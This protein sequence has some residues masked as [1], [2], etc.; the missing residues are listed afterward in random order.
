MKLGFWASRGLFPVRVAVS[1]MNFRKDD[2]VKPGL[3]RRIGFESDRSICLSKVS[4]VVWKNL[5]SPCITGQC[6][7]VEYIGGLQKLTLS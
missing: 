6:L 7:P 1:R 2:A 4:R 3:A 5:S